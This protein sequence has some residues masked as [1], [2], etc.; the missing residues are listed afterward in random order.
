MAQVAAHQ[1]MLRDSPRS[2]A[3]RKAGAAQGAAILW[4]RMALTML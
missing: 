1:K 2:A 3:C 4:W